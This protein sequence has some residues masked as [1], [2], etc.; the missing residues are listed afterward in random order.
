M[1]SGILYCYSKMS[2]VFKTKRTE[3]YSDI[4]GPYGTQIQHA[5]SYRD[6]LDLTERQF[7]EER[8][9]ANYKAFLQDRM[10]CPTLADAALLKVQK[11][12][13]INLPHMLDL[14]KKR[15]EKNPEIDM[16]VKRTQESAGKNYLWTIFLREKLIKL[17][18][19]NLDGVE[20]ALKGWKKE[21]LRIRLYL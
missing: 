13:L 14:H 18:R 8:A 1:I 2:N 15:L 5:R 9:L 10:K 11:A 12:R 20:P 16:L 19:V 21:L 4:T 7:S 6:S 17:G 3:K